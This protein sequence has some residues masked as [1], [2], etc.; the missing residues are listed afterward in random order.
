MTRNRYCTA[1]ALAFALTA[2]SDAQ[3]PSASNDVAARDRIASLSSPL[4]F[5]GDEPGDPVAREAAMKSATDKIQKA[6]DEYVVRS[7]SAADTTE[8]LQ[9]RLRTV[10][11]EHQPNPDYD[12]LPLVKAA[13]LRDGRSLVIAYTLVRGPHHNLGTIRG[14]GADGDRFRLLDTTGGDFVGYGMFKAELSS[15]VVGELWMIVWGQAQ[16][17]NGKKVRCRVIAFDGRSF[18]TTW[19][20]EDMFDASISVTADGFSVEH[21]LRPERTMVR[22]EYRLTQTGPTRVK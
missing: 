1:L 22:E 11:H 6:V 5:R 18:R 2:R 21:E 10:L 9:A 14:Y 8:R 7:F 12:D 16:G 19:E 3:T 4:R 17:F 15:P 20:P 13:D